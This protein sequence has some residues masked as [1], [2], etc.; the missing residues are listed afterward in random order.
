M[1]HVLSKYNRESKES[2]Y[3]FKTLM[4]VQNVPM[5]T[6]ATVTTAAAHS[7][8]DAWASTE[9]AHPTATAAFAVAVAATFAGAVV[10]TAT[11]AIA[12]KPTAKTPTQHSHWWRGLRSRA[13]AIGSAG[14][15]TLRVTPRAHQRV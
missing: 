12:A 1:R 14:V 13:G 9:H 4:A 3:L 10:A 8:V 6:T 11:T 2:E 5:A 15:S 7:V